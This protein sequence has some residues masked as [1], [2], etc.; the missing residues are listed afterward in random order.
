MT[1]DPSGYASDGYAGEATGVTDRQLVRAAM[2]LSEPALT[3][4]WDNPEDDV[5]NDVDC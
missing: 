2:A 1:N 4:V 3:A 5:Y